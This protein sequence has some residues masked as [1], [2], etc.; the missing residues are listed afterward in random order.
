M[1]QAALPDRIVLW[2]S[3]EDSKTELITARTDSTVKLGRKDR[4]NRWPSVAI[5]D[6][7]VSQK[8]AEL[9]WNETHWEA[10]DVGSS[11]G[12]TLNGCT[13]VADGALLV[14][15]HAATKSSKIYILT[16]GP[17]AQCPRS[18]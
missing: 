9:R 18:P 8:H 7:A 14:P 16:S 5:K 15:E 17:A 12:T 10:I 6:D 1:V 13:L 4:G 11:N 2:H 3:A